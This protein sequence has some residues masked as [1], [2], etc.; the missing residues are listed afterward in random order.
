MAS[1][2]VLASVVLIL[3]ACAGLSPAES[4]MSPLLDRAAGRYTGTKLLWYQDPENPE[5]SDAVVEIEGDELHYTWS[6]RGEPQHGAFRFK[7]ADAETTANWTDT[8]HAKQAMTCTGM[9]TPEQIEVLTNY[10]P[11]W[12]WRTIVSVPSEG[13]IL[14]EM[15]NIDPKGAEQPAVR[16]TATR[17]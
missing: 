9:T 3:P 11:G 14:I 15:I 2:S 7:F 13:E 12:S 8:W 17:S 16:L 10:G 4:E 5:K 6:F 1:R